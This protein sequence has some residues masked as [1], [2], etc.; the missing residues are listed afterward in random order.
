MR[1]L[2]RVPSR[3]A[4]KSAADISREIQRSMDQGKDPFGRPWKRGSR[5]QTITLEKTGRGRRSIVVSATVGAGIKI[6]VS[7]L[8]MIY[9]QFGGKSHLRGHKRNKDFGRDKDQGGR[10]GRP[11]KRS[12]LPMGNELPPTWGE[13]IVGNIEAEGQRVLRRG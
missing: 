8:Y 10:R 12:F 5:G 2:A 1:D 13:I 7:L 6:V 4:S 11:P 9:H 3:V